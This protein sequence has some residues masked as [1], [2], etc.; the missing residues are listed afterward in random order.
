M[1]RGSDRSVGRVAREY[2]KYREYRQYREYREYLDYCLGRWFLL[3]LHF[4]GDRV[5][6]RLRISLQSQAAYTE[7]WGGPIQSLGR[8]DPVANA[9]RE[10]TSTV[11]HGSLRLPGGTPIV[12]CTCIFAA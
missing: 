8:R 9:Q 6:N 3:A 2:R 10:H 5:R 1:L 7:G 4:C 12:I 11:E